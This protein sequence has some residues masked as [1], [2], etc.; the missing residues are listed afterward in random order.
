M[1]EQQ[2]SIIQS[3]KNI[4][5]DFK[6]VDQSELFL[7]NL[8]TSLS[9]FLSY[10][11]DIEHCKKLTKQISSCVGNYTFSGKHLSEFEK[12]QGFAERTLDAVFDVHY[13]QKSGHDQSISDFTTDFHQPEW[14]KFLITRD[15]YDSFFLN[16]NGID[17]EYAE[18]DV[19]EPGWEGPA[20]GYSCSSYFYIY[21][22]YPIVKSM[23]E[24]GTHF[25][26]INNFQRN[27]KHYKIEQ[28]SLYEIINENESKFICDEKGWE[29]VW[30]D[31]PVI[32][33][34]DPMNPVWGSESSSESETE[35][36]D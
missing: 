15:L 29:L 21:L 7:E 20:E 23:P 26:S 17:L 2:S 30:K 8:K 6:H 5:Q 34:T 4:Y 32:I 12:K 16:C 28:R 35:D 27:V 24:N 36:D 22:Q 25:I 14:T 19:T 11:N 33:K 10:I 9:D 3:L 18:E 31:A 13:Y 1:N